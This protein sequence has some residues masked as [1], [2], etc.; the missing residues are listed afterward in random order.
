MS[1]EQPA[2]PVEIKKSKKNKTAREEGSKKRPREEE[3]NGVQPVKSKKNKL[4]D[5]RAVEEQSAPPSFVRKE[6]TKRPK[7]EAI[8]SG[9]QAEPVATSITSAVKREHASA[10]Q[11][12]YDAPPVTEA[13]PS[14]P[15]EQISPHLAATRIGA[16]PH[17]VSGEDMSKKAKK[18]KRRQLSAPAGEPVD[19]TTE[20]RAH[21]D[22]SQD[23]NGVSVAATPLDGALEKHTP[24]V[25]QTASFYLALSPCAYNFPLEGM[26]AEHLS[27]LLL[28]YYPPLR[29]VVL[30]YSNARLSE[31][32]DQTAEEVS[33]RVLC[34]SI[35]EYAVS[36]AWLTAEFTLFKPHRGTYLEG[37]VNLQNESLLG[38]VCYNFFNASIDRTR[39]PKDWNWIG[40]E[41]D[42][43]DRKKKGGHGYF[44]DG[45][46]KRVEGRIT[47]RAKDFDATPGA[48][49]GGGT[50]NISGTLLS[51]DTDQDE[52]D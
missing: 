38:L 17:T 26:C 50:I 44:V 5:T 15:N 35:D 13:G 28:T 43:S 52:D 8:D 41:S 27:P 49:N 4:E 47:F 23:I 31:H 7:S 51:P 3:Q 16:E 12:L 39:L 6:K 25:Q 14:N 21:Q 10:A 32:S 48:E 29:G 24:F 34:K 37:H 40:D 2:V 11:S 18:K 20:R 42:I 30:N 1:S 46:G 19:S 33:S 45:S 36:F 22:P 9:S